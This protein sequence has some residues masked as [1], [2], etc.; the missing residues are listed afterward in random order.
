MK[1]A[2]T[3]LEQMDEVCMLGVDGVIYKSSISED[4]VKSQV[5]IAQSNAWVGSIFQENYSK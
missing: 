2:F 4:E 5:E 1:M 3:E